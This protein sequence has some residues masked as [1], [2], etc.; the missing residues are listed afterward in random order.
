[1]YSTGHIT[2]FPSAWGD[3]FHR[4]S[5]AAR[6]CM[7]FI[8][9]ALQQLRCWIM[10]WACS[11]GG[12]ASCCCMTAAVLLLWPGG[13]VLL[14]GAGGSLLEG[15]GGQGCRSQL[16]GAV[17]RH[18]GG[19]W[20]MLPARGP[21]SPHELLCPAGASLPPDTPVPRTSLGF[22]PHGIHVGVET[23]A[24]GRAPG[25]ALHMKVKLIGVKLTHNTWA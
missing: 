17:C 20:A 2:R 21:F 8:L 22:R 3:F 19:H 12:V 14:R 16:G 11:D 24:S 9:G 5:T 7:C 15:A 23:R 4:S 18:R 13:S 10:C 25:R 1:M 6:A